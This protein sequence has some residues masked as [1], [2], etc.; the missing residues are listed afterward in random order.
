MSVVT[1]PLLRQRLA[2]VV[3]EVC[4]SAAPVIVTRQN[5]RSV[6]M[7]SLEE[8]ESMAK[9]LHLLRSP[10][11]AERLARAREKLRAMLSGLPPGGG[12]QLKIVK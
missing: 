7:L 3:D 12:T 2:A 6:V 8:Y 5:A 4:D 1:Y 9:T 11:N 10:R